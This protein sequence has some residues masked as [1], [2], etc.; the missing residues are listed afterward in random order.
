[1]SL[2]EYEFG[3]ITDEID[4][5]FERACRIAQ[6]EGMGPHRVA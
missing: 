6:E 5:D 4:Q 2:K 3:V 1:M